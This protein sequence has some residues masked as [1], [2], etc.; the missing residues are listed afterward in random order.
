MKWKLTLFIALV[1]G[2]IAGS[3]VKNLPGFVIIAYEKTSYEMRLWVAIVF[4][5]AIIALLSLIGIFV[6]SLLSGAG[7]VRGWHGG[8]KARKARRRTL[9]GMLAFTEG[10]WKMSEDIMVEAAKHSDTKLIN[11]LIAA[12][13]A[14]HQNAEVRR[15]A[16]LRLAH[17]AE[18][19]AKIAVGLTQAQLQIKHGQLEQALASLKT[20]RT[21]SP[22][23]PYVLKLLCRLY[24]ELHDWQKIIDLLPELKKQKVFAEQ[25]YSL[26][27]SQSVCG[28]LSSFA[29]EGNVEG[30]EESWSRMSNSIRK[31]A[32]HISCYCKY[33]IQFGQMEEAEALLRPLIKKSADAEV[34]ALYAQ[35]ES[36]N[37]E[38]QFSFIESWLSS[39][40]E[41]PREANL[42]AGKLAFRCQLWGKARHYLEKALHL[43]PSAEA[44]LFMA[45]TLEQLH[46][47]GQAQ[48]CYQ[49]GLNFAAPGNQLKTTISLPKGSEDLV[50]QDLL[51]KFQKTQ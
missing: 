48:A 1:V 29:K 37:P 49:Q 21:D 8:R 51:P 5:V 40:K 43:K 34:L 41:I 18:P 22:S 36:N 12:Q 45:R 23:H 38:K 33:L 42:T 28:V 17:Q 44:Y 16:Y 19:E 47:E 7:K 4:I 30:L 46:E 32:K 26:I 50:S 15:D 25:E 39:A 2:A 6:R 10:R 35:V 14:Q 13:S 11:Y 9:Q 24:V 31:S 3:W 27:E 20:L